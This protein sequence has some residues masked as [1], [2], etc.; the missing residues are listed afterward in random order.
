MT[1]KEIGHLMVLVPMVTFAAFIFIAVL[2]CCW[3]AACIDDEVNGGCYWHR[4]G[5]LVFI[6]ILTCMVA[7]AFL[8]D[9]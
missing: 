5:F 6:L 7:G 4:I 1:T 9:L 8:C 3:T 2:W